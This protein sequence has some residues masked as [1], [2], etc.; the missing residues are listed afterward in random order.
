LTDKSIGELRVGLAG[1]EFG[2]RKQA[3]YG[4]HKG[5]DLGFGRAAAG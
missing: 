5:F 2:T 4:H 1:L 3:F